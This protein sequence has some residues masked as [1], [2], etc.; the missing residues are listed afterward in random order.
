MAKSLVGSIIYTSK[1]RGLCIIIHRKGA[2]PLGY[3][4]YGSSG[5]VIDDFAVAQDGQQIFH[6]L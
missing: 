6:L 4:F 2:P 1:E 3:T 5:S